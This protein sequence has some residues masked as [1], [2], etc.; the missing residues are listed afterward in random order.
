MLVS[1]E[2]DEPTQ[3]ERQIPVPGAAD[4]VY[5]GCWQAETTTNR[6][7]FVV[8]HTWTSCRALLEFLGFLDSSHENSVL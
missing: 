4:Y 2:F 5:S 7:P 1:P 3:P 8:V 6:F